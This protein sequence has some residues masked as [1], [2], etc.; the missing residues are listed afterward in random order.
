MQRI[1]QEILYRMQGFHHLLL[2]EADIPELREAGCPI[3]M[4]DFEIGAIAT[5]TPCDHIFHYH[6][7]MPAFFDGELL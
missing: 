2:T 5:Q 4:V 1:V 3:C 6:C 7:L